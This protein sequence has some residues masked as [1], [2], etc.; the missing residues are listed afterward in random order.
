MTIAREKDWSKLTKSKLRELCQSEV[1]TDLAL[2]GKRFNELVD[3]EVHAHDR[4][5]ADECN[6]DDRKSSM[7][8]KAASRAD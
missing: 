3:E 2:C 5:S 6:V 4:L 1:D 8:T 7:G